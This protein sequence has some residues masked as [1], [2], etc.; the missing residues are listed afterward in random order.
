VIIHHIDRNNSNNDLDN[1]A[2]LCM[3]CHSRVTGTRGLGKSFKPGE[4]KRYKRAWDKQVRDSRKIHKPRIYYKKELV[5]QVDL[6][7]CE[8]L[9]C[10]KN[11]SRQEEL[12]DVLFELHLWRGS[13]EIDSK[14]LEGL[15]HLALMG[16]LNSAWL[17]EL[18][19]KKTWEM[20]FHY[21]GPKEVPM[22]KAGT[23]YVLKCLDILECLAD[24]GCGYS[25]GKQATQAMS[26]T[27]E[28][29]FELATWYSN[30]QVA[31]AVLKVYRSG[32][33]SCVFQG[34]NE[35]P[36]GATVLKKSLQKIRTLLRDEK[37]SWKDIELSI[38]NLLKKYKDI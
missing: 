14:I 29:F 8:I 3:D 19:A 10:S 27:A 26:R 35:F 24:F 25:R 7:V 36:E 30:K 31:N 17:T 32:L 9:A 33:G 11:R 28:N 34:K 15:S 13:R 5:S 1:L 38:V 2:V 21:V 4:V 6:I 37:P 12:L 23:T 18:I 16:G 20:A 22:G